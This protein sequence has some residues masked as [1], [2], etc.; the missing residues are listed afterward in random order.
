MTLPSTLLEGIARAPTDRPVL[1]LLRHAERDDIAAGDVGLAAR[2]TDAGRAA[3]RLLGGA[4]PGGAIEVVSSPIARCV[5]T[6]GLLGRGAPRLDLR[7]GDPGAFI[8]DTELAWPWFRDHPLAWLIAR[9]IEDDEPL[10]GFAAPADGVRALIAESMP[11]EGWRVAVT[12]DALLGVVAGRV[13]GRSDLSLPTWLEGLLAWPVPGGFRVRYRGLEAAIDGETL[14]PR[15]GLTVRDGRIRAPNLELSVA[16]HCNLAC[17][18]CSHLSP[19]LPP[20]LLDIDELAA[21]LA[22][23]ATVYHAH[24]V[25]LMGGEPLLHP[26]LGEV[27]AAVRRSGVGDRIAL[28]TNGVLLPKMGDDLWRA[29][30]AVAVSRYPDLLTDAAIERARERAARAGTA[31]EVFDY[32]HFRVSW[33]RPGTESAALVERIWRTCHVAHRWRCHNLDRGRFALCPQALMLPA[34][35]PTLPGAGVDLRAPEARGARL[36]DRLLDHL[37]DPR[38]LDACRHCLG[39]AGGRIEHHQR[40]RE[41]EALHDAPGEA[42]VDWMHL[43]RM[44]AVDGEVPQGCLRDDVEMP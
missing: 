44:E 3:A 14:R 12:H 25:K 38:S 36:L 40:R 31:F 34:H 1:L 17:A 5:E 24:T 29:L 22:R 10:P 42:L 43:A 8:D 41:W 7:L 11:R 39:T 18:G 15:A 16:R 4:L 23:L 21:D 32:G 20:E 37:D 35:L 19:I 13:L 33:S 6:A 2:L 26:R 30:D 27:I 9:Q 28:C